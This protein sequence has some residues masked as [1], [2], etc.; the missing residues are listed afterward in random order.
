MSETT[1]KAY[2]YVKDVL[3]IAVVPLVLLLWQLSS[4]SALQSE[5][6][7]NLKG[8]VTLLRAD[9]AKVDRLREDLQTLA[10]QQARI[11]G[12]VESANA[13]LDQIKSLLGGK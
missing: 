5:R 4:H 10:I 13:R 6:I 11:E 2:G 8:E 9:Q 3:T 7:E 1:T 12:K